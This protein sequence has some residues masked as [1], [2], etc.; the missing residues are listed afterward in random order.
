MSVKVEMREV[1]IWKTPNGAEFETED[2]YMVKVETENHL[3][4]KLL[5]REM[6]CEN[7]IYPDSECPYLITDKNCEWWERSETNPKHFP[8][9]PN[10]YDENIEFLCSQ[11]EYEILEKQDKKCS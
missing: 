8:Y 6:Y 10:T 7:K 11:I 9:Q 4:A 2:R 1:A 3:E 5:V